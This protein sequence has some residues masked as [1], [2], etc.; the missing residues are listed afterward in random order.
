MDQSPNFSIVIPNL[1]GSQYLAQCL[2]SLLASISKT[3]NSKFEIILID[4]GST[5]DSIDVFGRLLVPSKKLKTK[6]ILHQ[7][8]LGVAPA[9]AQGIE[10]SEYE[11]TVIT[12]NDI[13]IKS[14]W[15]QQIIKNIKKHPDVKVF[16]GTVLNRDGSKI[17]SQGL[18]FFY[19]GKCL[20]INNGKLYS[21]K[22]L[23]FQSSPSLI[24]GTAAAI[25]VYH[26]QT[27]ID[28]GNFDSDFFAYEEDVDLALRLHN[29]NYK[30]L[31]IPHAISYHLG[32]ATSAKMG[33]FRHRMD[34]KN[35]FFII[36][37]NYSRKDIITNLLPIIEERLR[38]LS[39]LV[40][41]THLHLLAPSIL[42]TYWGV[43][44][45]VPSMIR[46]RKAIK[47][48]IKSAR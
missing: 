20:N 44:K 41:N 28:I 23:P 27:I 5:D 15:F 25:A 34:A 38:N 12:N 16:C 47:K 18:E 31:Y 48:L 10:R 14:D 42:T 26:R 19:R 7:K 29:L 40:K 21:S 37:K 36:I 8:N 30:T 32:G 2:P 45:H 3:K 24:W 43:V 4:N 11:W 13:T 22:A 1:N 46:K 17:E 33:N 9:F 6:I 39:Y 35:W